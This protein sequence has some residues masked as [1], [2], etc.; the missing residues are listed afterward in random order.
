[1]DFLIATRSLVGIDP[2]RLEPYCLFRPECEPLTTTNLAGLSAFSVGAPA[3]SGDALALFDGCALLDGRLVREPDCETVRRLLASPITSGVFAAALIDNGELHVRCDATSQYPLFY[4]R[5]D[6]GFLISNN[7]HLVEQAMMHIGL[8]PKRSAETVAFSLGYGCNFGNR[9]GVVGIDL[10]PPRNELK[11]DGETLSIAE[12]ISARALYESETCYDELLRAAEQEMR[13]V[14]S[15]VAALDGPVYCDMTGGADSRLTLAAFI[16]VGAASRVQAYCIGGVN[17]PDRLVV[18][19][20]AHKYGIRGADMIHDNLTEELEFEDILRRGAFRNAGLKPAAGQDLGPVY[21][22]NSSRVTGYFGELAR[23]FGGAPKVDSDNPAR[24]IAEGY[25]VG[26]DRRSMYLTEDARQGLTDA[27]TQ[28][29][30]R[31]LAAGIPSA[32]SNKIMYCENR[33]RYHFGLTARLMNTVRL[34]I[35]PLYSFTQIRAAGELSAPDLA[36]NKLGFDLTSRLAGYDFTLEPRAQSR[37][38]ERVIPECLR[39]SYATVP[40]IKPGDAPLA[41]PADIRLRTLFKRTKRTESELENLML[42]R[43]LPERFQKIASYRAVARGLIAEMGSGDEFWRHVDR[44]HVIAVME[45]DPMTLDQAD[46]G[47]NRRLIAANVSALAVGLIWYMRRD[48]PS[49]VTTP[50]GN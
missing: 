17:T 29:I 32:Q 14:A 50:L 41:P 15:A 26:R 12:F 36:A 19:L 35:H 18:D 44:D 1:M 11:G 38:S 49:T 47:S 42:K 8:S 13:T 4:T 33:S 30:E 40:T 48:T 6:H 9:S 2:V 16:G 22:P 28:D 7:C 27:A 5:L 43:G 10:L 20:L 37:W 31:I 24:S 39:A 3:R 46:L 45:T 23:S 25:F 34:A 21:F